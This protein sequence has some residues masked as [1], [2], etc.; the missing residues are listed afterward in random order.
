MTK[1]VAEAIFSLFLLALG[2]VY[3]V[4]ATPLVG[5]GTQVI[6]PAHFPRALSVFLILLAGFNLFRVIS[7][8]TKISHKF[9]FDITVFAGILTFG[10][11]I[12]L[13]PIVGYFYV[14]PVFAVCIM[15]LMGYRKPLQI[16]LLSGGFTLVAYLIFYRLMMVRLPV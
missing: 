1:W 13:I 11:Y 10:L 16:F 2:I 5:R 9:T 14:T 3:W 7:Q 12:Y 6:G 8:Q 4:A 15:L